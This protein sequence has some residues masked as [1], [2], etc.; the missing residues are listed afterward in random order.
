[1]KRTRGLLLPALGLAVL[2]A[3]LPARAAVDMF[4]SFL[5]KIEGESTDKVHKGE[6][7]VLS[8]SWGM[9]NSGTTHIGGG[10]G[11]GKANLQDLSVTKYVDKSS[12]SLLQYCANGQHLDQATLIVRKAGTTPVEYIKIT[13]TEVMVVSVSTGGSGGQDRLTE[14]ITLNFAKI[15]FEYVPLKPDGT[16]D[17]SSTKVMTWSIV[18]NAP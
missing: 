4:L 9:S 18:E 3:A 13:M 16:P 1:M 14:N 2:L 7:D 12:A 15:K 10:A 8:W 17:P 5:P 11:A 6:V